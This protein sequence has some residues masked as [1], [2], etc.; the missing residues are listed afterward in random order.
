M[1]FLLAIVTFSLVQDP[2]KPKEEKKPTYVALVGGDLY[3]VTE[4]VLKGATVIFKDG[5]IS[6][7]GH[8]L[9]IPEGATRHDCR[10]K[11][12]IPGLVV[13]QARGLGIPGGSSSARLADS[14]DPYQE[15]IKIALASGITTVYIDPPGAGGMFG[16]RADGVQA[17]GAVI[18]MTY[19]DLDAMLVLEPAAVNLSSWLT[20]SP[21]QR[22]QL[23]EQF[24]KASEQA[25]KIRDYDKRRAENK[26]NP[27]EQPPAATDPLVRLMRGDM[28]ARISAQSADQIRSACK[29]VEEFRFSCVLTDVE[30]GWT[31]PDIIG[32][33]RCGC[34]ITPR[35]KRPADKN[36]S[37]PTGWSIEQAAILGKAGVTLAITA[38]QPSISTG[39]M[40]GRDLMNLPMEAGFAIR[41]GLDEESALAAITIGAARLLGVDARV[42]SIEVG[43]DADLL[44]L[45]GDPFDYRTFVELTFIE[46]KLL[47]DKHASPYFS[48]IKRKR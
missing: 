23:R 32:R 37:R 43:K 27:N 44:V 19:G 24:Q 31:V 14:L 2:P 8:D 26:L 40:A 3:T 4:G 28:T 33:A 39:G 35:A 46:G 12:V 25:A 45:D 38:L 47:Y 42:G 5:K 36:V 16:G 1:T 29:L 10:G 6:K 11:R 20:G 48:H 22:Q 17:G 13:A 15:S 9:E 34:I 30:E 18:K 21:S 41:G 7:I